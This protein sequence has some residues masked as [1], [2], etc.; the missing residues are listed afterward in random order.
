MPK[1]DWL[2]W[3]WIIIHH[4]WSKDHD[5]LDW[6]G[7]RR[8]HCA[9]RI[10]AHIVTKEEYNRRLKIRDGKQFQK[11]WFKDDSGYHVGCEYVKGHHE[12]LLGRPLT[13]PGVQCK[14]MNNK[15]LG[16]CFTGNFDLKAPPEEMLVYAAKRFFVPILQMSGYGVE[17]IKGH[18]DYANKSCPGKKFDLDMFRDIVKKF[19]WFL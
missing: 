9:Y 8:Y 2:W 7:I 11:P 6:G 17:C 14:G 12:I 19:I 3:K 5:T 4:S 18:R 10:D 13:L 16:F 15:S 1:P